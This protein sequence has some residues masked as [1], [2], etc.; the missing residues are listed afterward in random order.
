MRTGHT[1]SI[2]T[3]QASKP[4]SNLLAL[5]DNVPQTLTPLRSFPP[6]LPQVALAGLGRLSLVRFW[7]TLLVATEMQRH[8]RKRKRSVNANSETTSITK[9]R[10]IDNDR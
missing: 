10:L 3:A 5:F 9:R 8:K 4:V 7:P 1:N 6:Q 2:S